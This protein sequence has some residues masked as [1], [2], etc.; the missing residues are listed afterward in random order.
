MLPTIASGSAPRIGACTGSSGT[1]PLEQAVDAVIDEHNRV[2]LF[3]ARPGLNGAA[4]PQHVGMLCRRA[5]GLLT[6]A[7]PTKPASRINH[8]WH[9]SRDDVPVERHQ[10]HA[11]VGVDVDLPRVVIGTRVL[12]TAAPLR[13]A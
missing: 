5:S 4:G 13:T 10:R 3:N 11:A 8:R 9:L 12:Y 1:N 6:V 2:V 7:S